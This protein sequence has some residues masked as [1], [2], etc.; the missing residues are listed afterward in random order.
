V[1]IESTGVP[2]VLPQAVECARRGGRIVA[3]GLT[4]APSRLDS[5]RLTFYERSLV[6]SLGYRHDLPRVIRMVGAGLVDPEPL[7]AETV[8]LAA[9]PD[10]FASLASTPGDRVKVMV[11]PHGG[12]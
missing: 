8:P 5:S 7:I 9:A 11:D 1:V 2:A 10:A 6:G 3:V 4:G 12:P